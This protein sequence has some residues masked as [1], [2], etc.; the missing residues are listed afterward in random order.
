MDNWFISGG[1]NIA[2]LAGFASEETALGPSLDWGELAAFFL[3]YFT[4]RLAVIRHL[5]K[6]DE[7]RHAA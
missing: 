6:Q 1:R 7:Q 5:S 4:R 2:G 3:L